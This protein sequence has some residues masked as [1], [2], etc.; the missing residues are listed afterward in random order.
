MD[1]QVLT[2]STKGQISLPVEMRRQLSI[3]TG[4]RLAHG[5]TIMLKTLKL[6]TVDEFDAMLKE[7]QSW[8][9]SVGYKEEDVN[10]IIK[11]YRKEK[12][13]QA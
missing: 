1:A 10:D 9:A 7:A 6:P 13:G 3:N 2:V 4:D 8:A 5:D 11:S 12:R